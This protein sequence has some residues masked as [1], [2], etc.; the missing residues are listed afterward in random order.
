MWVPP[1]SSKV[2]ML[3]VSYHIAPDVSKISCFIDRIRINVKSSYTKTTRKYTNATALPHR[4]TEQFYN[5]HKI[6]SVKVKTIKWDDEKPNG[7]KKRLVIVYVSLARVRPTYQ[8]KWVDAAYILGRWYIWSKLSTCRVWR[9]N[10][11]CIIS[12]VKQSS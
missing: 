2:I 4:H 6:V 10:D 7:R 3:I 12:W 9:S 8:R 5:F 1:P 11:G